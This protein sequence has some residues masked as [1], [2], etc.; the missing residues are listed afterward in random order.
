MPNMHPTQSTTQI[1]SLQNFL[2]QPPQMREQMLQQMNP[3]K[4][5]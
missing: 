3:Q 4:G 1:D 2:K 5:N